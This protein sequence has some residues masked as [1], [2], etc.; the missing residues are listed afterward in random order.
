M[1]FSYHFPSNTPEQSSRRRQLLDAY[2]QL[3]QLSAIF[4]PLLLFQFSF[5]VRFIFK[6]LRQRRENGY[7]ALKPSGAHGRRKKL[8]QSPRVTTFSDQEVIDAAAEVSE[9]E[10]KGKR[11]SASI[12]RL[13]DRLRWAL[14]EPVAQGWGTCREWS[15]AASW[16]AWLLVLVVRDTG[17]GMCCDVF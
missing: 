12:A 14:D 16:T 11:P 15:I 1:A 6:K 9:S 10:R 3:A 17:D 5:L 2:G 7:A 8:R 4:I 13:W